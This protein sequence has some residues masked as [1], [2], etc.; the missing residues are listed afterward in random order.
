MFIQYASRRLQILSILRYT[1]EQVDNHSKNISLE[2]TKQRSIKGQKM[3]KL[4]LIRVSLLV[5]LGTAFSAVASVDTT[6]VLASNTVPSNAVG[7]MEQLEDA[8]SVEIKQTNIL[9]AQSKKR[10]KKRSKGRKRIISGEKRYK[11]KKGSKTNLDFDEVDIS[12]QRKTPMGSMIGSAKN[13]KGFNFI[14]IRKEWHDEMIQSAS[15]LD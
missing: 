14:E 1:G 13:R 8:N 2:T 12:G 10:L 5:F 15:N 7:G 11:S 3:V 4:G 6:V 9:L